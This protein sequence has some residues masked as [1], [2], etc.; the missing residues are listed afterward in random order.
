MDL[1]GK[2]TAMKR[3]KSSPL[4]VVEEEKHLKTADQSAASI[5]TCLDCEKKKVHLTSGI[6]K[7]LQN[8]LISFC[9]NSGTWWNTSVQS[10][11]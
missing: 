7:S 9:I 2:S 11:P 3:P 8:D 5:L 10:T 6:K 4:K 1:P